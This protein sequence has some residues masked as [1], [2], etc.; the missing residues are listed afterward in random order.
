[1]ICAYLAPQDEQGERGVQTKLVRLD[2]LDGLGREPL[3]SPYWRLLLH[4]GA[5]V[6]ASVVGVGA[7][8]VEAPIK[9]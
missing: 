6:G 8:T 9:S 2:W 1:M 7:S 3:E 5:R 4:I